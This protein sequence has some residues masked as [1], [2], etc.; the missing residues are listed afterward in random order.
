MEKGD[1]TMKKRMISIFLAGIMT[2]MTACSTQPEEEK[3]TEHTQS[4]TELEDF[5]IILDWYPNAI[6]SFLYVAQEKGYYAEE[7][8]NVKVRFPANTNDALSLTAAGKADMGI[9]YLHDT[10]MTIAKE[11]IPI[12]S[13]G[14]L[15]QSPLNIILSLKEKNITSPADLVGKK[16]GES[17][18]IISEGMIKSNMEYVGKQ[19]KVELV[20][21]GFDLMSS[22]TTGKV[23]ATIG[24]M[25]NHEV[26]QME[27]EGF[28]VQYYYP[29][30]YGVP[31]YYELVLLAGTDTLQNNKEKI[32]KFLRAS[33]KGFAYTKEHPEE[34][35]Q[36]LLDHQNE[37]NFPLKKEVEQKSMDILLPVMETE[38]APFLSQ[39]ANVWQNNIDWLKKEG[40]IENE[41]AAED[42]F[43]N[44]D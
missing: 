7:G 14:A 13:V 11:N 35:L 15:V 27:A 22:M 43:E 41:I 37:E 44:I 42:I 23:D 28:E 33:K 6:H 29:N 2:L 39:N 16:V 32:K 40:L 26:P 18:S 36:I 19:E 5:D 17:G 4:A 9:Y 10:I 30:Q 20:D 12:K 24:C 21:V 25:I 1:L 34:A 8:L 3:N 31:D 38:N